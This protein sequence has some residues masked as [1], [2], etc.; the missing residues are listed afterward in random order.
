MG[1]ETDNCSVL[2]RCWVGTEPEYVT[3]PYNTD[4]D[5]KERPCE[6]DADTFVSHQQTGDSGSNAPNPQVITPPPFPKPSN[7][8][9]K[10]ISK[11]LR[12]FWLNYK[13]IICQ[14]SKLCNNWR[15]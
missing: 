9:Y 11:E 7:C 8:Y 6:W 15:Q 4:A 13:H 5:A 14:L 2:G 1:D 10:H 12:D 3:L